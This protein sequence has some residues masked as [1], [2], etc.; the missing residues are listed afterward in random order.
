MI[1]IGRI[2]RYLFRECAR[3]LILVLLVI[4]SSVVVVDLVEQLR[5]VGTRTELGLFSALYLSSLKLP[6]LIEQTLP[7]VILV[8]TMLTF[9][10]L[11]RS[12]ELPVIRA[13]GLSAWR[14]LLPPALLAF[15]IGV[16][17]TTALSPLGAR[18]KDAFEQE[19]AQLLNRKDPS[20]T[21]FDTGIWLR[22]GDD[23]TETVI[24][25]ASV[26]ETGTQFQQVKF[27]EQARDTGLDDQPM[28]FSR[29]IDAEKASLRNGFWQLQDIV[30]NV[31]GEPPRHFDTLALPTDLAQDSLIDRFAAPQTIG[32]WHLPEH[33]EETKEA[34][35]N[36]SRYLV[37]WHSL[38]A[39]PALF[40]A[41][42][43]IGALAC[44]KLAR[45]GGTAPIVA[46]AAFGSLSLFF[47][48]RLAQGLGSI[49][50]APPIVVAWTPPLFAI[51]ACLA[52]VAY[53]EDG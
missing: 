25:A 33:I 15:L 30:E 24:Q 13:S 42:A 51:F 27:I 45:L 19:R 5:T 9:R 7:F 40:V 44:L 10:R 14:F 37:R 20:L 4:A 29:R 39:A 3:T 35:L 11:S 31:P 43:L 48:N 41:M 52:I 1:G 36:A 8:S 17:A 21:V 34:G 2:E 12:A 49:G 32:F 22:L 50:M 18:A 23:M 38:L 47:V 6:E 16:F 28:V 26:D 46:I 53:Q